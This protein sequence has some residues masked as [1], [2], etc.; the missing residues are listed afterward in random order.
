MPKQLLYKIKAAALRFDITVRK[1]RNSSDDLSVKQELQLTELLS[2]L[3]FAVHH[4]WQQHSARKLSAL[5]RGK[6]DIGGLRV[7]SR[8]LSCSRNCHASV[9]RNIKRIRF[10]FCKAVIQHFCVIV[11]IIARIQRYRDKSYSVTLRRCPVR[12]N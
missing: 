6:R 2:R 7:Y 1:Q 9:I 4:A 3:D 12:N 11:P 10:H 5:L 8:A